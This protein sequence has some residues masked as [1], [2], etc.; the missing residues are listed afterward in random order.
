MK[1]LLLTLILTAGLVAPLNAQT[2][3]VQKPKISVYNNGYIII[4]ITPNGKYTLYQ[5]RSEDKTSGDKIVNLETGEETYVRT[6]GSTKNGSVSDISNDGSIAVG[7]Y[8]GF[9]AYWTK[10]TGLWTALEVGSN[11]TSGEV[12][13]VTADGKYAVGR[14]FLKSSSSL[15]TQSVTTKD[16]FAWSNT[17]DAVMWDLSTGKQMTLNNVPNR[18]LNYQVQSQ[19]QFNNISSDGRYILGIVAYTDADNLMTYVYDRETETYEPIGFKDAGSR[20][21]EKVSGLHHIDNSTMSPNGRYVTGMAFMTDNEEYAFKYSCETKELE[22]YN[23]AIDAG[24]NGYAVDDNGVV[25]GATPASTP[26]RDMYVR[27]GN[28]W[29]AMDNILAQRYDIDY[30]NRSGLDYTGTPVAVSPDGRY[31]G[32]FVN[33]SDGSGCNYTFYEDVQEA[34]K[35]VD[36]MGTYTVTPAAGSTFSVVSS[37]TVTFD[38]K[39]AITGK[40]DAVK[41]LDSNGETARSAMGLSADGLTATIT[42]RPTTLNEGETY[43]L[44]IPAGTFGMDGD[45]DVQSRDIRINYIGR[46]DSPVTAGTIYPTPGS[47]VSKLDYSSSHILAYFDTN[48]K[49]ADENT[50]ALVYRNDETDAYEQMSLYCSGNVL[51]IYPTSTLYFFKGI[52]YRIV[53]PAGAITD[54]GGSGANEELVINYSGNYQRE[55]SSTD[56]LLFAEDFNSGLGTQFMFYEGDKNSPDEEMSALG[57]TAT[58]TPWWVGR[59]DESVDETYNYAAMSTSA[60]D[61]AG[62]SDDWMVT[63]SIYLPNGNTYLSFK[64][65]GYRKAKSDRLSVYIIPTT[66]V[67]EALTEEAMVELRAKKISLYNEIVSP[68]SSE[69][70]LIDDW[71]SVQISLNDYADKDVYIAFVNEN[72]DQSI[73]FVDDV[74]VIHDMNYLLSLDNETTVIAQDNVG[75]FGHIEVQNESSSYTTA[76]LELRDSENNLIDTIDESGLTIDKDHNYSFTFAKPLPL[77]VG[78]EVEFNLVVNLGSDSY[79]ITRTITDL[80][81][82]PTKRVFLEEYA[83]AECPNCPLGTIAME[84]L[85]KEIPNNFVGVTIRTF[86][87]D[88][89]SSGLSAYSTYLGFTAAP[90]AAINRKVIAEPMMLLKGSFVFSN[91]DYPL[92]SDIIYDELSDPAV[93]DFNITASL[94]EEKSLIDVPVEVTYALNKKDVNVSLF[95][96]V[97]EDNLK[98]YQRNTLY[99]YTDPNL[100]EWG[101]GGKYGSSLIRTYYANDIARAIVG[102]TYNGT[103]GYVPTTVE[104]GVVNKATVQFNLPQ[105]VDNVD[106]ASIVGVMI[107]NN[108]DYVINAAKCRLATSGVSNIVAENAVT[109]ATDADGNVVVSSEAQAVVNVYGVSGALIGTAQ[110]QGTIVVNTNGYKGVAVARVVTPSA[111]TVEKL[112]IR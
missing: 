98:T 68:G 35:A 51:A 24:I 83:G 29:Y 73:V 64:T 44:Y 78:S 110:G 48:I 79:T 74:E 62:K 21:V 107:D 96:V 33:P 22:V 84:K 108:T 72:E 85:Q 54:A 5:D 41:I 26:L 2:T 52:D 88:E 30:A 15:L 38:R 4:G 18:D 102:T 59:D 43:T 100:G 13:A 63:P 103:Q 99:T 92:W 58:S 53:L 23:T 50:K 87:S 91:P 109:V 61:P 112:I 42:F 69:N 28:Y 80:S 67:Y 9:P 55:V 32:T 17:F 11:V 101:N 97:L 111:N 10:S 31:I 47:G 65:Q 94:D 19:N 49:I 82:K 36:L 75:I 40:K 57:F 77:T 14:V 27:S 1:K 37:I 20:F 71:T 7:T 86:E 6:T 3:T 56:K 93:A 104:A 76:H 46:K 8:D 81:F 34:C 12:N 39:I 66:K 95:F 25:Y 105:T 90:T 45:T 106:N 89:L 60:Y 70:N 16:L